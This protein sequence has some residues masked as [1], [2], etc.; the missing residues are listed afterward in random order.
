MKERDDV[1][2]KTA[3][4]TGA[5]GFIGSH[6]VE[7]LLRAGHHV[8][9]MVWY[10]PDGG[11]GDLK[12]IDPSVL[13]DVEIFHGDVRDSDTLRRQMAG[14]DWVFHLAALIGI[15]YSFLTPEGYVEVNIGGTLNVLSVARDLG[16]SRVVHTSTSEVYGSAQK[17]P[18]DELHPLVAQSPYAATKIAAD[19]LALSFFHAYELPV[20]IVRPFNTFG[21]RQSARA[22]IPQII[23]QVLSGNDAVHLGALT[24]TRDF[25][26]VEDTARGL[27]AGA[28]ADNVAG[29]VIN[30]G[31][32]FEISIGDIATR[33]MHLM[34]VSLP[35]MTE[36]VRLRPG[37]SEVLR[38]H[39]DNRRA[40]LL[41]GWEPQLSGADRL[42]AGLERTIDW[43]RRYHSRA[44]AVKFAI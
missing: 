19:Q 21:P 43:F 38:L 15:P 10:R 27:L 2:T 8:K 13:R 23:C 24:P 16:V 35:I 44:E 22:V 40:R 30:L 33:I 29:E 34:N 14:C 5:D 37:T 36:S 18:M 25:N 17:V 12:F 3:L 4:V 20:T 7:M 41:L 42:D 39:S 1:R 9:A 32:G 11:I 31:S 28:T 26:Y 6:L